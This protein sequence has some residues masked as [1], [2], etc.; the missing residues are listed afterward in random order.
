[1]FP[2][3]P[4]FCTLP[5]PGIR[6]VLKEIRVTTCKLNPFQPWLMKNTYKH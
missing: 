4:G 1:M 3:L 6:E 2:F 5:E